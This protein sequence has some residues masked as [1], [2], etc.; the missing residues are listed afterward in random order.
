MSMN[1]AVTILRSPL[2]RLMA[3][4]AHIAGLVATGLHPSP[5][6]HCQ[7]VTTTTHKTL[8]GPRGGIILCTKK[9]RKRIDR[10]LFPGI[11][12]G[13]LMHIIAAKAVAFREALT[14]EFATYQK[15]VVA[16]AGRLAKGLISR[17]HRIVSG[18]TDNHVFLLDVAAA[19]TTGKVAEEALEAAGITVNKNT[20]PYDENPPLV[21][22]GIRIGSP[23][24]TTRGMGEPEME[25]IA[26]LIADVLEQPEDNEAQADVLGRVRQLCREFPLYETAD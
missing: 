7:F 20:I 15:A 12:G 8:R 23:A 21:A 25:R 6:P 9:W 10:A 17:G 5:V 19:G 16:N 24:V 2:N 14:P 18:G 3:D 26:G 13:P 1:N 4:I 11:Q 22:S